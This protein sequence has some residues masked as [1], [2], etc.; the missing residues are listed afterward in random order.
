M[1][2]TTSYGTWCNRVAP[3]STSPDADVVDFIGGG[4]PEWLQR[5]ESTGAIA[6]IQTAY[7][8]AIN[9]ALPNSVSLCGDEFI[10]PAYPD[11]NEFDGYPT[12]EHG[13]LDFKSIAEEID[14]AA[15]VDRHDV[16]ND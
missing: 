6:E 14:L 12:D 10:G 8:A 7:R 16:D 2:T 11:D 4:D 13:A 5:M 15:I 3:Y 1:T 9:A